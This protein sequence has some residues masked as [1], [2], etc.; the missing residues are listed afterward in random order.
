MSTQTTARNDGIRTA[1]EALQRIHT[2]RRAE[3]AAWRELAAAMQ[4]VR[5][6]RPP[7]LGALGEV[8]LIGA[9]QGGDF[10]G[11]GAGPGGDFDGGALDPVGAGES[12]L[13]DLDLPPELSFPVEGE[14]E[15]GDD[16]WGEVLAEEDA[17]SGESGDP[18]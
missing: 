12:I 7:G 6:Y 4:Q 10:G 5:A 9:D 11:E 16:P 13:G 2:A 17:L 8:S 14:G 15:M 1:I 3:A 18:L